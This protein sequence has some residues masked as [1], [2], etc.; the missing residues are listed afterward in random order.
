MK[1]PALEELPNL[2]TLKLEE[3]IGK[4]LTHEMTLKKRMRSPPK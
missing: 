2:D 3:L 4:L 1:I